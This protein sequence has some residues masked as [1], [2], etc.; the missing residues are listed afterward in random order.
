MRRLLAFAIISALPAIAALACSGADPAPAVTETPPDIAGYIADTV[1]LPQAEAPPAAVPPAGPLPT[2]TPD[3]AA[4]LAPAL[5]AA[6]PQP[7]STPATQVPGA[8]PTP[9]PAADSGPPTMPPPTLAPGATATPE[10]T[11]ELRNLEHH[12]AMGRPI[13]ITGKVTVA[14]APRANLIVQATS[15]GY[16]PATARTNEGGIYRLYIDSEV[17]AEIQISVQGHNSEPVQYQPTVSGDLK[18]I[19]FELPAASES[20]QP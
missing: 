8:E 5:T 13:T 7:T 16:H 14:G 12:G 6:A 19:N 18:L 3:I 20:I 4:T 17:R 11:T 9:T 1:Q 10:P 15:Q 2:A